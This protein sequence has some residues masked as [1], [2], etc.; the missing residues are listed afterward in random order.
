MFGHVVSVILYHLSCKDC[1][2]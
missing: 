1:R 2:Y